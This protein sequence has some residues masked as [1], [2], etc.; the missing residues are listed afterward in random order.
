[1][2][3]LKAKTNSLE[4]AIEAMRRDVP[5]IEWR[6]G[7]LLSKLAELAAIVG[8]MVSSTSTEA[9][10]APDTARELH[11]KTTRRKATVEHLLWLACRSLPVGVADEARD[12]EVR[13]VMLVWGVTEY[14]LG[15]LGYSPRG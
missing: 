15:L 14:E 13:R 2:S 1:V 5:A 3:D 10:A 9:T 11:D 7:Q 6:T 4:T 12:L 8:E